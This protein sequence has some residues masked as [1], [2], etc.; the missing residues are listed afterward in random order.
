MRQNVII[1]LLSVIATLLLV[2]V[3]S[4]HSVVGQNATGNATVG[5]DIAVA[6]GS[7]M[8]GSGSALYLYDAKDK[9]L[10]VYFLGNQ[11]LEVRA[12]RDIQWD[13]Q[14]ID[15]NQPQG[16][17]TSVPAMRTAVKKL[18]AKSEKSDEEKK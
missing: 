8:G 13:L 10:A 18:K 16:K 11:G 9:I 14:A 12:V 5:S 3:L 4:P 15:F 17:I 7:M 2:I 6:T 1:A